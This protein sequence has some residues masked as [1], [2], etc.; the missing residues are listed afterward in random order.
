M[1]GIVMF[2]DDS[3]I[4]SMELFDE[5]QK[6]KWMG[7]MSVGI[8]THSGISGDLLV[9]IQGPDCSSSGKLSGWN[10]FSSLPNVGEGMKLEW[11]GFALN[12]RL[13]WEDAEGKPDWVRSLDDVGMNGEE[14]ESPLSLVKDA[15]SVEPLGKCGNK[16]LLWWLRAEARTDTKFPAG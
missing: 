11:A 7:A 1:D 10:T 8:L 14:V 12:A 3:N 13:L 6:V 4:H 2:A 5:I 9:P 15:S 16:V